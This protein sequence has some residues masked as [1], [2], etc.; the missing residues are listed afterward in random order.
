M[1]GIDYNTVALFYL[2]E[3]NVARMRKL[4]MKVIETKIKLLY[5]INA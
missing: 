3:R 1:T 5:I 4:T 2:K